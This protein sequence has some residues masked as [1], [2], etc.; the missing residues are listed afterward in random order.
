M[1]TPRRLAQ[2]D[3]GDAEWGRVFFEV[4]GVY[5]E[6]EG[7][8]DAG[9]VGDGNGEWGRG[10]GEEGHV[11]DGRTASVWGE[12]VGEREREGF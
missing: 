4:G 10:R 1:E 9:V 12:E 3:G 7:G 5:G 8:T 2:R 6:M 11:G